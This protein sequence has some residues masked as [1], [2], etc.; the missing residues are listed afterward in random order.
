MRDALAGRRGVTE[1]R[2]FGGPCWMLNGN[3]LCAVEVGRFLFR[4]GK[5]LEAEAVARGGEVV[6]FTGRRMGGI[7]WVD[8]DA[9]LDRGLDDWIAF[10]AQFVGGLPPKGDL[11]D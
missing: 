2:M 11:W 9:A 4:V 7:V 6:A 8:A 3:M 10:A 5:A 1:K